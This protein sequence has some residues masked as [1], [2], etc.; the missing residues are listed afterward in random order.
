MSNLAQKKYNFNHLPV[1][2]FGCRIIEYHG[3]RIIL[4]I[5]KKN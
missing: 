3:E 1:A 2:K 5:T 4:K